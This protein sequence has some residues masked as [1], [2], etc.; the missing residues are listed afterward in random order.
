[1]YK[2]NVKTL[3]DCKKNIQ[4]LSTLLSM[5]YN[6]S[7]LEAKQ[8]GKVFKKAKELITKLDNNYLNIKP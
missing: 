8:V 4:D 2:V 1:M 5:S 6:G 7:K 3:K